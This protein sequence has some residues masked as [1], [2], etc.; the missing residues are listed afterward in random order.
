[1]QMPCV[2]KCDCGQTAGDARRIRSPDA[3]ECK[4]RNRVTADRRFFLA[5]HLN[6]KLSNSM[7]ASAVENRYS[8]SHVRKQMLVYVCDG[9][10]MDGDPEVAPRY[11][12]K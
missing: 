7:R 2:N 9:G 6:L 3:V 11:D 5:K 4:N 8:V 1:M 12:D 10:T